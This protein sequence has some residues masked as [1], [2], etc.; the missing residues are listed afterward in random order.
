MKNS[1][2]QKSKTQSLY[3]TLLVLLMSVAVVVAIAGSVAKNITKKP[4]PDVAE[5]TAEPKKDEDAFA[6]GKDGKD[7]EEA[8][9]YTHLKGREGTAVPAAGGYNYPKLEKQFKLL[10]Q[11]AERK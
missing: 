8:V 9:S 11:L 2:S 4:A 5:T 10:R 7:T 6:F 3:V 1:E